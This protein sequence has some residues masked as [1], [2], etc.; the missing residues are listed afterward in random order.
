MKKS[1]KINL[2]KEYKKSWDYIKKSKK[3]IWTIF[4]IFLISIFLG[5]FIQFPDSIEQLELYMF[6]KSVINRLPTHL[7]YVVIYQTN[8]II[9]KK[10]QSIKPDIKFINGTNFLRKFIY[11]E[12]VTSLD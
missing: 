12:L 2:K 9:T 1:K 10:I 5:F 6:G 11:P 8:S 7:K 3:F 4:G